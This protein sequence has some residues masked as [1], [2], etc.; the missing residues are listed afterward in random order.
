MNTY[1][2]QCGCHDS[3]NRSEVWPRRDALNS[4][5]QQESSLM[6]W[7]F[8]WRTRQSQIRRTLRDSRTYSGSELMRPFKPSKS[9]SCHNRPA[10]SQCRFGGVRS[11]GRKSAGR[12]TRRLPGARFSSRISSAVSAWATPSTSSC[13]YPPSGRQTLGR[14]SLSRG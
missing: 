2:L 7:I 14:R 3:K 1:H 9:Y 8:P 5:E 11:F 13:R 4:R 12:P 6:F 10:S